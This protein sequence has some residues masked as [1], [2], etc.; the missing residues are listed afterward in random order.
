M[1]HVIAYAPTD[2][3]E[4]ISPELFAILDHWTETQVPIPRPEHL[5]APF[6]LNTDD[7]SDVSPSW[8][9]TPEETQREWHK[10]RESIWFMYQFTFTREVTDEELAFIKEAMMADFVERTEHRHLG[11]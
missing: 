5:W 10:S 6:V 9:P 4:F 2:G 8:E 3:I 11:E 1:H 7:F